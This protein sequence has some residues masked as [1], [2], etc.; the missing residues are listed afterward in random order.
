M[1]LD[2][3]VVRAIV[4]RYVKDDMILS[5]GTGPQNEE[6]LRAIA[7]KAH[8]KGMNIRFV[9]TSMKLTEIASNLK[10]KIATINDYEI[11]LAIEFADLIDKD[12]NFISRE[13]TSLVRDKMVGQSA[14]EM[15]VIAEKKSYV[16]QLYGVIPFEVATF[17][18]RHSLVRLDQ[19]GKAKFRV[20]EDGERYMT[21]TG[22]Y[23]IDVEFDTA[24]DLEDIQFQAKEVPGVLESGLFL[25]YADRVLLHNDKIHLMSR[26]GPELKAKKET[27]VE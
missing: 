26:I 10:L 27:E 12:F 7:L 17:G 13:T 21:E 9:P 11:D 18:S 25:D 4:D 22:H 23:I 6:F 2:E 15:L 5:V 1:A 16:T 19:F 14:A 3:R 8:G 24:F 20:K